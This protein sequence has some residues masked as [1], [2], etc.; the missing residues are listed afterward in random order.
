MLC[1]KIHRQRLIVEFYTKRNLY[2]AAVVETLFDNFLH[3]LCGTLGMEA[4]IDPII[5]HVPDG[6]SAYMMWQ[7]SGVQIH[8]WFEHRFVSI[9]IYSCKPYLVS[10]VLD[11]IEYWFEPEELEVG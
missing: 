2:D 6:S 11:V 10:D 4:I 3:D 9:D 5:K 1:P 8:S 7:E